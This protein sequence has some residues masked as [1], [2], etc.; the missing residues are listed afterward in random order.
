MTT[1]G[2]NVPKIVTRENPSVGTSVMIHVG[3]YYEHNDGTYSIGGTY[4]CFGVVAP[5]Q[6]FEDEEGAGG[7][8]MRIKDNTTSTMEVKELEDIVPSNAEQNSVVNNVNKAK[9]NAS[10]RG[11]K[12]ADN[13]QVEIHKRSDVTTECS[14]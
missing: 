4:G 14:N 5:S 10:K 1:S 7:F 13:V 12:N 6:V 11:E 8:G 9:Q 2:D 3:G